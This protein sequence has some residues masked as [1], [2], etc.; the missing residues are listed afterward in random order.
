MSAGLKVVCPQCK[1]RLFET[2]EKYN[3]DISPNGSMVRFLGG[4]HI[5]WLTTSA[6]KCSEM[7]CPECQGQ[8]APSGR[9]TVIYPSMGDAIQNAKD[10]DVVEVPP[11]DDREDPAP[12]AVLP[13][14]LGA[15]DSMISDNRYYDIKKPKVGKPV[16]IC[17]I[18]GKECS[19]ALALNGHMRSHKNKSE[20]QQ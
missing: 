3:P 9:L 8:L 19:T 5:D 14:G 10:G 17:D 11:T 18:C 20:A 2:T 6:T 4:Y 1:R 13:N 12:S 7:A 15:E 16:H